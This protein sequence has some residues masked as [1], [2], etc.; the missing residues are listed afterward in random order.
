MAGRTIRIISDL[1]RGSTPIRVNGKG[2][3][4]PHNEDVAVSAEEL[5][6]LDDSN[7]AYEPAGGAVHRAGATVV[8]DPLDH[9]GNGRKGGSKPKKAAKA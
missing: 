9:D 1:A 8:R 4:I 7:V 3:D 2:R 5:A 6:V